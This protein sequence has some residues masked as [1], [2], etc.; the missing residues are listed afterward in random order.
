MPFGSYLPDDSQY[1]QVPD[2]FFTRQ[3]CTAHHD[4]L[5]ELET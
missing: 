3:V 5:E 4:L 2:M 1:S